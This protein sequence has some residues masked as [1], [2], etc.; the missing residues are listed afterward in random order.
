MND[1]AR[2]PNVPESLALGSI[3][4]AYER[5]VSLRATVIYVSVMQMRE[6]N[7][8]LTVIIGAHF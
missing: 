6:A 5:G 2:R 8:D 7:G 3:A 1:E 4:H